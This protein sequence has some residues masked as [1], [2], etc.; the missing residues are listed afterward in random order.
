MYD[1][2][3]Y[4]FVKEGSDWVLYFKDLSLKKFYEVKD[5]LKNLI[6]KGEPA[7]KS[8]LLLDQTNLIVEGSKNTIALY[9]KLKSMQ[10]ELQPAK[11]KYMDP[12]YLNQ[13]E[14]IEK[15]RKLLYNELVLFITQGVVID[16]RYMSLFCDLVT[17]EGAL[18]SISRAGVIK[19]K[20]PLTRCSFEAAKSLIYSLALNKETDNLKSSLAS[21]IL[22]KP[23][24]IGSNYYKIQF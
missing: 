3:T 5:F 17:Y 4:S 7:I 8:Y 6:V 20:S 9:K 23:L 21:I 18:D 16:P 2:E 24:Q 22:G 12:I 11:L 15:A 1:K 13:I 14:G 19:T 10:K